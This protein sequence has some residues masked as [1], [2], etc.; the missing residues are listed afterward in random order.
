MGST[1]KDKAPP[2]IPGARTGDDRELRIIDY[3]DLTEDLRTI[4][5]TLMSEG[6]DGVRVN[7]CPGGGLAWK[8]ELNTPVGAFVEWLCLLEKLGCLMPDPEWAVAFMRVF[9]RNF[10]GGA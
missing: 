1:D 6:F 8:I 9:Q 2:L 3:I 7:L 10:A 5:I 4:L